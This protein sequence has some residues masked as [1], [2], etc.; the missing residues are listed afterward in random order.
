MKRPKRLLISPHWYE[1]KTDPDLSTKGGVVGTCMTDTQVILID[2]QLGS[3]TEIETVTHEGLH[4]AW[5]Q[6]GLAKN[7]TDEQEEEVIW[8]LTPRIIAMLRDNP[9]YVMWLMEGVE[10]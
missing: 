2:D 6:T 9:E 7:Y 5:H 8:S 3:T 10:P 1:V 4:G